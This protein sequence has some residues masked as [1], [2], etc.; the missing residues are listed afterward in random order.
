[1][2]EVCT[3]AL[4]WP[5][6]CCKP[7]GFWMHAS[8]ALPIASY[9]HGISADSDRPWSLQPF[10]RSTL[11]K[12]YPVPQLIFLGACNNTVHVICIVEARQSVSSSASVI[13]SI[14]LTD[15]RRLQTC[16]KFETVH[17]TSSV[18]SDWHLTARWH[19]RVSTAPHVYILYKNACLNTVLDR[20]DWHTSVSDKGTLW[21]HGKGAPAEHEEA[22]VNCR[23]TG[24]SA[25][26]ARWS[27]QSFLFC[28]CFFSFKAQ[29]IQ[30]SQIV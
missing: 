23:S 1:M 20:L 25:S 7:L 10:S 11:A 29:I 6:W 24:H 2:Y 4:Q 3:C 28:V 9:R 13:M 26:P 5:L 21:H 18:S 16:C 22:V 30:L 8:R 14:S 19:C 17:V 27:I 15:S 12:V